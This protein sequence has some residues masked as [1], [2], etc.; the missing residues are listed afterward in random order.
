MAERPEDLNLPNAVVTRIIKEALPEGVNVS[1]EAR[2]AISRAASVFVLYATSCANNFAMKS[3]RKTLN[4][5]DVLAAM[6]EMEFER[7]I[8]PL[9]DA[10]EAFKRDQKGKKE[11]SELRKRDKKSENEEPD[12]SREEETEEDNEGKVV[13]DDDPKELE[14]EE[15]D[16]EN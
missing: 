13:E 8:T 6:E 9:K 2:S 11:A 7:F 1:K 5:T 14:N 16:V 10:L 12:K 15:E 4:A 3:K